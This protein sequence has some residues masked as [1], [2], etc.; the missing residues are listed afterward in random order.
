MT[1]TAV[2]APGW[3]ARLA[4]LSV[5]RRGRVVAL[6]LLALLAVTALASAGRGEFQV[7]YTAKGSDSA[8]A[9]AL[10]LERFP[11]QGGEQVDVVVRAEAGLVAAR[12]QVERLLAE[13]DADPLVTTAV[14]PYAPG[15]TV[16]PD[17]RTGRGV[18][19]LDAP[20]AEAVPIERTRA[21]MAAA[22]RAS[23]DGLQV[24]LGGQAISIADVGH[25]GSEGIGLAAAAVVL[26][27]TFG[28]VV[29]A[30]L[31]ILVAL[32][33]L[34]VSSALIGLL[35]AVL[36]VP[37]WATSL[38]AM[39]G[40]G[41]GIDYVLLML[42]RY[43]EALDR[44]LAPVAAVVHT[45][46]T[47]GRAVLVAGSTVIISLLGLAAMGLSYMTG[48]AVATM[49]AVAV[50]VVAALT[51][52]PAL[53]GY[54]GRHV[55]RLR[56]IRPRRTNPFR[57]GA[58]D[59]W[60]RA[61]Q[62]RPLAA[63]LIGTAVLG[64]LAAPVAGLRFG[65]PDAGNEPAGTQARVAYDLTVEAFGQGAAGP[66]V[67]A[68][69]DGVRPLAEMSGAVAALPGVAQVGM[70]VPSPDGSAALL[71]VV[72]ATGP[73]DPA[74][75]ELV[76][77]L[78]DLVPDGA[79]VHVGGATAAFVD[80]TDDIADRFPL[81]VGGVVGVSFLLLLLVFRSPAVAVK[82]ALLNLVS[83]LAAFG[84]VAL[85]LEGG[86]A[87]QLVGIDTETPL[88]A[89]IPV[90]MFAIL[91]GLSM[92]YEVFLMSAVR[93]AW[94]RTGDSRLAVVAGI[95]G[96]GRVITAAAAIMVAVF[97]AFIPSDQVFLK[98]IGVGLATAILVDATVVRMLLVPAVMQ[99]LGD[100]AWWLP[101][102]LDRRMPQVHVEGRGAV[103]P[104]APS[105]VVDE[106]VP[107]GV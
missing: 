57:L 39:M 58:W 12:P 37:D 103:E 44:G 6:W 11:G 84:V 63:L 36:G 33:G 54:L 18:L 78:R 17:G 13:L 14:S 55:D 1:V 81:L 52:L 5:R 61:V 59:R 86:W 7:D 101:R 51:L 25:I 46:D 3:L 47:A 79:T 92:D 82:A 19:V 9:S 73:Q 91:F 38:A 75:E 40:I 89:F 94:V 20:T 88:P 32:L 23:T 31:P 93:E 83:I 105:P 64:V 107:A 4:A 76:S 56:V 85:V 16:S 69:A 53:L 71:T 80:Q 43:R 21:L 41:V 30:G 96:T 28:T 72:P 90:L 35:A 106:R 67:L 65:F 60:A 34:A 100:R 8:A 29:A 87:G 66:L 77:T 48:A 98:V 26:L 74:T 10:L 97:A 70:P 42:T 15:G 50:V 104:P 49:I 27:L 45:V 68:S 95:S 62:R 99:L 102:W 24:A 22:E 2:Q